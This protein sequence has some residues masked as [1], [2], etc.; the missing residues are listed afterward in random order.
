MKTIHIVLMGVSGA[1]KTTVARLLSEHYRVPHVGSGDIARALADH[2]PHTYVALEKG[3]MAPEEAMRAEVRQALERADLEDGGWILEGFPRDMAQLVCLM[4]WTV[5]LPAFVHLDAKA[6][7]V[8]E[9]LT[10]RRRDDDTPDAIARRLV[11]FEQNVRPVLDVL[12][13]G[14]V[15]KTAQ[16]ESFPNPDALA[17][18]IEEILL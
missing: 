18:Y 10:S 16:V 12:A 5:A 6:W 1:G 11:D 8:I 7:T 2:D 9:R 3:Q 15:L 14:G 4:D 17:R 13:A